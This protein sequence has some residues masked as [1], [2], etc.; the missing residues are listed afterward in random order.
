MAAVYHRVLL[1]FADGVGLAP[2]APD[3]PLASVG[4]PALTG[5]LG[6]P[7]TAEAL[8]GIRRGERGGEPG[9]FEGRSRE[10]ERERE[11]E[12]DGSEGN[13]WKRRV[14]L[15]ALDATLGV[16]GLPQ[17]ATGQ[18]TLFTGVNAASLVGRHV[19]A[20]PGPRLRKLLA[21][22]SVLRRLRR[23]GRSVTFANAFTA[24]YLEMLAGDRVRP[25]AT[26]CA[27]LAAQVPLRRLDE[28]LA[29][30]AVS[31]DVCRDLF[32]RRLGR[33]LSSI[34]P[35]EAGRHL[36]A[37]AAGFHLTLYETF[38]PDLAGHRRWGVTPEEAVTRL[39]GLIGGFLEAADRE[40]TLILVSDH[41]NVEEAGHRRH[42][43]NPVPLLVV[44]PL[45]GSF[46]DVASLEHVAPRLVELLTGQQSRTSGAQGAARV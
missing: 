29:G 25:S 26:T 3:N 45:A 24:G 27:V 1:L 6:G 44:G 21:E 37:I 35:A 42:T 28:L 8:D 15:R 20:L 19:P 22:E 39:D 12:R 46:T 16:P 30:E 14:E 4:S 31:F 43:R 33:P 38:L 23:A 7:L 2:A 17:S 41:G 11:R 10:R 18:A 40:L 36:A 5:L 9:G 13:R 34:L 32:A